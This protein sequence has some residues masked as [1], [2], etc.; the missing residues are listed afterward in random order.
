MWDQLLVRKI[1]PIVHLRKRAPKKKKA[2]VVVLAHQSRPGKPDFTTLKQHSKLINKYTKIQYIPDVIG[3]KAQTAIK[4]LK[5]GQALL[6]ENIRLLKE[7]FK[8]NKN[9]KI[10]KTLAPLADFYINDAFSIAHRDQTSI[11]A[12]PKVLKSAIGPT[13]EYDLKHLNKTKSKNCYYWTIG[14]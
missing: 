6:L 5:P 12:F 7:E 2:K 14:K 4:K 11:T 8:P 9:N 13:L 3:K 1:S 10:V